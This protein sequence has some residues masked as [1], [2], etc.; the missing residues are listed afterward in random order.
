MD[1]RFGEGRV[2]VC[3]RR[4]R[5]DGILQRAAVAAGAEL[6]D[7]TR[8]TEVLFDGD[9]A[10][11]VRAEGPDGSAEIQAGLVVGADGRRS[12]VAAA[13]DAEEYLAYDAPRA[14]YWAY[15]KA[16]DAW[17]SDRHPYDLYLVQ[18]G[19]HLRSVFQTDHDHLLLG[20]VPTLEEGHGWRH[21]PLD[22]LR[23]SLSRDPVTASLIG[24]GITEALLQA[25]S[26]A[27][28][29]GEGTDRALERWWRARDVEALPSY[30]WARDEGARGEPGPLVRAIY[31][32]VAR[33]PDLARRMTHLPEHRSTPYDLLPAAPVLG[34]LAGC[35]VRGRF[36]A[37]AE[38]L[39]QGRRGKAFRRE[40][41]KRRKL[42]ERVAA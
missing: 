42:L 21:H 28:A 16:P 1:T 18:R 15:W 36:G 11:G 24:D 31:R 26:L 33:D 25:R 9:R 19:E 32:R 12:T 4:E 22:C 40:M 10:V 41:A 34:A 17:W 13:V 8:V 6:R 14:I 20:S 38:F 30:F 27:A 37:I 29:I 5:L 7:R 39:R 3:P 23:D 2:E 35:L